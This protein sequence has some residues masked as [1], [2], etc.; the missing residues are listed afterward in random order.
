[1]HCAM[2]IGV[3][4]EKKPAQKLGGEKLVCSALL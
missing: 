3:Q 1:M 4:T 2:D